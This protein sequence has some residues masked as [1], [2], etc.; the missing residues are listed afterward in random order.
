MRIHTAGYG[1]E[2]L[3]VLTRLVADAKADD[4]LAPVTV[5]VRDEIA[6]LTVRRSLARGVGGRPGV[7]AL[8]A[9]T[10]RRLADGILASADRTRLPLTASRI[11]A[12]WREALDAD[13]GVL[14][15][16]AHHPATV[17]ALARAHAELRTLTSQ[18]LD[19]IAASNVLG[20]DLVR[21]HRTVTEHVQSTHADEAQILQDAATLLRGDDAMAPRRD[22]VI[23]HLPDEPSRLEVDLIAALDAVAEIDVVLGRTGHADLDTALDARL[24]IEAGGERASATAS[25]VI[26]ASDADDEVRAIVRRVVAA[27]ADGSRAHRIAVLYAKPVPYARLLHDHL[28][29]AGVATNGPG[30]RPLRDRAVA[31]GFLT[32]LALD[33]D[34]LR[35]G[36]VFDWLGRAP[37]R[38]G[39]ESVP[40]TAWERV[41][42]DAGI[43]G[44]DWADRL[45]SFAATTSAQLDELRDDPEAGAGR[46]ARLERQIDQAESLAA[47]TAEISA[48][49]RHGRSL[50]TWPELAAWAADA[51]ARCYGTDDSRGRLPEV[52]QRAATAIES[53]LR[54]LAE[55]SD[56]QRQPS[57]DDLVEIL[58]VELDRARPRVGRFGEGVFV[59]PMSAAASLDVDRTFV[60]GLAEDLFPGRQGADPLLPETIR[61]TTGELD[62][63]R[64][65]LRGMRRSLLAAFAG[66]KDV[67]ASLARGDLRRG[68]ARLPSRWLM[69]TLREL[70]ACATLP[71]TRWLEV[72]GAKVEAVESHW[73]GIS[74]AI[75]PGTEQEWRLRR[76]AGGD[77][78]TDAA[79]DAAVE[80][81]RARASEM[82][83]RF[84]GNLSGVDGL[85][86]FATGVR[87]V[88]PTALEQYA[89]C[90]H[91]YFMAKVLFVEPVESPED[92]VTI[93][94]MDI[95]NI[96]HRTMDELAHSYEGRLPGFGEPWSAE[97][98]ATM[99]VIAADIMDE[100]EGRGLTGHPRLWAR[101]RA[102]L[103]EGLEW[104]LD[105]DDEARATRGA[106]IVASELRFGFGSTPAVSIEIE[107]GAVRMRGSADRVDLTRDGTLIVTDLKTG[108]ADDFK[109]IAKGDDQLVKGTKLQLPLYALAARAAH[110]ADRVEA[111]YWFVGRRS[112][113]D[114]IDVTLDDSL[115][116]QY[117]S[118][119]GALVGGIRDGQFIARPPKDDDFGYVRCRYCNPDAVGYGH[120]RPASARKRH[121][122]S[123]A[124]LFAL[125]DPSA[126]T[127]EAVP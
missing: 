124:G 93:R 92:I 100:Y 64:D 30:V 40:R 105:A 89:V 37:I 87:A 1:A 59:G 11:T 33:P 82:F 24:G 8:D 15:D 20:R 42:R 101:E 51:F 9:T 13:P 22:R 46:I 67:T 103:L 56:L 48:T 50:R 98:R 25:N 63:I 120:V 97:Q 125:L 114:R 61:E 110:E 118:A 39:G 108:K 84:D 45:A 32:M 27:L 12:L 6:A 41:S 35:R 21:L 119:L 28:A 62:T 113:G 122:S 54:G 115:A 47:F 99:R 52:E 111:G 109:D 10:L 16:V 23:L 2:A 36:D 26:H 107:G 86:D 58:E 77:E 70:T 116:A 3:E 74:R 90:P 31:D 126:P 75:E 106:R 71:A 14:G 69:P 34:D 79:L 43:T 57:I 38:F 121:D 104:L 102:Q 65:R 85:P 19:A 44:G 60:V 83:T 81:A 76:Q 117:R 55:L 17:R 95:G 18:A 78:L 7:A 29:A 91:A 112:R 123:L 88:S 5:I 68:A 127:E 72:T 96:V 73:A 4:P 53:T 66:S 80:H 49:L 94:P